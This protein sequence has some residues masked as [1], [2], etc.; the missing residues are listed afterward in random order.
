MPIEIGNSHKLAAILLDRRLDLYEQALRN[1]PHDEHLLAD[2]LKEA[3]QKLSPVS[4]S[5]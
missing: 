1:L 3:A 4:P 5:H 2:Y